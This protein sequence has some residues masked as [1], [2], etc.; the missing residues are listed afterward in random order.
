MSETIKAQTLAYLDTHGDPHPE[1]SHIETARRLLE[2]GA[3]EPNGRS[4]PAGTAARYIGEWRDDESDTSDSH[5]NDGG[6]EMDNPEP[7]DGPLDEPPDEPMGLDLDTRDAYPAADGDYWIV[8]LPDYGQVE[9][10]GEIVREMK[11]AY[12]N[13]V[14]DGQTINEI[15]RNYGWGRKQFQQFKQA[16]GWTHDD[17]R[18]TQREHAEQDVDELVQSTL[19]ARKGEYIRERNKAIWEDIKADAER[20]RE[21]SQTVARPLL[22]QLDATAPPDIDTPE[23]TEEHA[24]VLFPTDL[25]LDQENVDGSGIGHNRREALRCHQS[26]LDKIETIGAPETVYLAVG[27]DMWNVD[28]DAG[29]TTAGTR[30]HNDRR[31]ASTVGFVA[32]VGRKLIDMTRGLTDDLR[33]LTVPGNHDRRTC[34]LYHW[35]IREIY[36]DCPDVSVVGEPIQRQYYRYG[37]NLIIFAH[38]DKLGGGQTGKS[39]TLSATAANEEP[40]MWGE[41]T[42]RYAHVGHLHSYQG[43]D[44]GVWIEHAPTSTP[45]DEWHEREGYV[46]SQRGQM[47]WLYEADGGQMA[48][49]SELLE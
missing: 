37:N 2:E 45:A 32:Q 38:G 41:T 46:R 23:R 48:R 47:A 30:Q 8:Y 39:K 14:D 43:H 26:L 19:Q 34:Q 25:H 4:D 5:A 42:H 20:Y 10:D 33:V 36:Q 31:P 12:S 1:A 49:V 3:I 18:Y 24:A 40:Q 7:S 35:A 22:D 15:A 16:L 44:D 28:T 6:Q 17:T 13:E 11:R 29:T 9:I 21:W 27:S